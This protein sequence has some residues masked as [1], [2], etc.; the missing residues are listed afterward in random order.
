MIGVAVSVPLL[1]GVGL[2]VVTYHMQSDKGETQ[3][4]VKGAAVAVVVFLLMRS[5][6]GK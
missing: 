4:A 2:G 6:G 5:T 1:M 3:A